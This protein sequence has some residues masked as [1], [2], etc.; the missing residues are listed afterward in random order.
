MGCD[1]PISALA[2]GGQRQEIKER[3]AGKFLQATV[4]LHWGAPAPLKEP[5]PCSSLCPVWKLLPL[6]DPQCFREMKVLHC[7]WVVILCPVP[8]LPS[9]AHTERVPVPP[10]FQMPPSECAVNSQLGPGY[11]GLRSFLQY[12]AL[13]AKN[14]R[15]SQESQ[16][17]WSSSL[18]QTQVFLHPSPFCTALV[19]SA[20]PTWVLALLQ[21][22]VPPWVCGR[23]NT[24]LSALAYSPSEQ[25]LQLTSG[26]LGRLRCGLQPS[27]EALQVIILCTL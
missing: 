8:L 14:P 4:S 3:E 11:L 19:L 9:P 6:L 2:S 1:L 27:V 21:E 24:H 22:R 7:C 26:Y 15:W 23:H 5:P 16:V 17:N 18:R 10:C 13:V 25:S 12:L 20:P